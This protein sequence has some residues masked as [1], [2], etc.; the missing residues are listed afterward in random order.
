[1]PPIGEG[2]GLPGLLCTFI[3]FGATPSF[4]FSQNMSHSDNTQTVAVAAISQITLCPYD[5]EEPAFWFCLIEAQFAVAGIKSQ[6]LRYAYA[7][8]SLPKQVLL[9][10]LDT[11]AVC[12][13]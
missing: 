7:L 11:V 6:K 10:I 13:K 4:V 12:N 1:M 8:I 5:E 3:F 2:G 9:D